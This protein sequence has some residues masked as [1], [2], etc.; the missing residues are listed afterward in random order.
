MLYLQKRSLLAVAISLVVLTACDSGVGGNK[1]PDERLQKALESVTI[2]HL[3]GQRKANISLTRTNLLSLLPDLDREYPINNVVPDS[4]RVE[5]VEIFVSPEKASSGKD[6]LYLDL[7]RQFNQRGVTIGNGKTAAVNVRNV[8]SGIAAQYVIAGRNVPEALSPSS[9]LWGQMIRARGIPL[10]TVAEV[11]AP[12]VAGIVVKQDKVARITDDKGVLDMNKLLTEVTGNQFAMGYTNP[13]VSSTGLN[14][15]LHTLMTFAQGDEQAVLAPDVASAFQAFQRGVP[16]VAQTTLQMRDA[17]VNSGVLDSMVMESQSFANATGFLGYTFIP[18]GIRHDSPLY[19]TE[20]ADADEREVL[21]AFAAFLQKNA[22][23][24]QYGFNQYPLYRNAYGIK[25]ESLIERAQQLW[26]D[27]K[28]GGRPV[29][30][31][32][33]A[34]TSGSMEGDRIK[35]AK[36]ALIE[37]A[38]LISATNAVGLITYNSTV[39]IDLPIHPFDLQQKSLFIGAVEDLSVGGGTA[40]YD[41][42]LTGISL[43]KDWKTSHPD[44]KLVIFVLSDGQQTEGYRFDAV[45]ELIRSLGIPVHSIAYGFD[46][47]ELKSLSSLVEAAYLQADE[48]SASYKIG[49]VLNAEL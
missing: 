21:A 42:V 18:F 37:S 1:P 2:T 24:H 34:D 31:V 33:I 8:S 15:L 12:N 22:D 48:G 47:A 17:A 4:A 9:A 20:A 38:D 3:E 10:E 46:S 39:N 28:S 35:A 41:G 13:Y 6:S 30:A 5:A 43:L 23:W 26:K 14:F 49:N 36:K 32:F 29:A 25:D 44:H 40:T 27:N 7:A 16:F 19:A 45:A 11:T